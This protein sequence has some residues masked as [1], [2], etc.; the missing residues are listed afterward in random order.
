[1]IVGKVERRVE[2]RGKE[3]EEGNRAFFCEVEVSLAF[4][5]L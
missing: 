5:L 1:M 4:L 2:N 3:E